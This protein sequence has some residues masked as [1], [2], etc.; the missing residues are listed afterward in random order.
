M[1]N[2]FK[3]AQRPKSAEDLKRCRKMDKQI[4]RLDFQNPQNKIRQKLK[5]GDR[6][7]L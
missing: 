6:A 4:R 2:L 1:K 7:I 5:K 3:N